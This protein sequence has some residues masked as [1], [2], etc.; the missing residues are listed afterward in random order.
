MIAT[1]PPA[2]WDRSSADD[3]R[4]LEAAGYDLALADGTAGYVERARFSPDRKRD[5]RWAEWG[6]SPADTQ[7]GGYLIRIYERVR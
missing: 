1:S 2:R 6:S 4:L 5:R 3:P 7:R